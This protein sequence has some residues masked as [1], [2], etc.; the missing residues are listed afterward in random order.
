MPKWFTQLPSWVQA[1]LLAGLVGLLTY[2]QIRGGLSL[3][4]VKQISEIGFHPIT[5]IP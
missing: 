3:D 4:Q 2:L 1:L 5:L